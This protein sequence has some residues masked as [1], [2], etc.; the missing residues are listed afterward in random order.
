[1]LE[2]QGDQGGWRGVTA[3]ERGAEGGSADDVV[4]LRTVTF[5]QSKMRSYW[6]EK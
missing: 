1:M 5:N 3:V 6:I 2:K 4:T